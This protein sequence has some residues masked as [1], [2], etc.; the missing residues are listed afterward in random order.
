MKSILIIFSILFFVSC[1]KTIEKSPD[2]ENVPP[3]SGSESGPS[4]VSTTPVSWG[5]DVGNAGDTEN[6]EH[7][8]MWFQGSERKVTF[9][10]IIADDFGIPGAEA[11]AQ[12]IAALENWKK[13]LHQR[14]GS[15][16][17]FS[18]PDLPA[19]NFVQSISCNGREDLTFFLGV[20]SPDIIKYKAQ[21]DN[22]TAFAQ[23]TAYDLKSRWGKGF[24][25]V[26]KADS[27]S[28]KDSLPKW[29]KNYPNWKK[30]GALNAILLH[31]IGHVL[32]NGHIPGTIMDSRINFFLATVEWQD[33]SP[34]DLFRELV[35]DT[36]TSKTFTTTLGCYSCPAGMNETKIFKFLSGREPEGRVWLQLKREASDSLESNTHSVL[37]K[38]DAGNVEITPFEKTSQFVRNPFG[39]KGLPL[40]T[41]VTH[42]GGY[43][44]VA[45]R[46]HLAEA[47]SLLFRQW[48]TNPQ[49]QK[50]FTEIKY[51]N[52]DEDSLHTNPVAI[53]PLSLSIVQDGEILDI[54]VFSQLP[55]FLDSL[56][57]TE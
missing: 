24:V 14:L 30:P 7:G 53:A 19:L 33:V 34:I 10:S 54:G 21:F 25:W 56:I 11:E 1:T 38:D 45:V 36:H 37:L 29:R 26:A 48:V 27:V 4:P 18:S 44:D 49:G 3:A 46:S 47:N 50:F 55:T 35:P 20:S 22:P 40:F 8:T 57:P 9:C 13:Y 5:T 42:P 52:G 12:V 28:T 16:F 41:F 39:M 31:E 6:P 32:G 51:Q 43:P 2:G 15:V 23:R 17:Q